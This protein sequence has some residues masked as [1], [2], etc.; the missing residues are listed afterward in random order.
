MT[1]LGTDE[2]LRWERAGKGFLVHIPEALQAAPPCD[3]A[4]TLRVEGGPR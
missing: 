4:W 2:A 3:Y 1:M